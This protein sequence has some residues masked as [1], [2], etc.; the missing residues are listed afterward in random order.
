MV[1]NKIALHTFA[2]EVT[3]VHMIDELEGGTTVWRWETVA[4][5]SA[6]ELEGILIL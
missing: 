1:I 5:E 6:D 4:R 2:A 3:R